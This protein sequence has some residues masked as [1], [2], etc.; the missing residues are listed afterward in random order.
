[1]TIMKEGGVVRAAA[2]AI[3]ITP[4]ASTL[5]FIPNCD[6][7]EIPQFCTKP[8]KYYTGFPHIPRIQAVSYHQPEPGLCCTNLFCLWN[9]PLYAILSCNI[10]CY[11]EWVG[12][13]GFSKVAATFNHVGGSLNLY[14]ATTGDVWVIPSFRIWAYVLHVEHI[15]YVIT[16]CGQHQRVIP[17]PLSIARYALLEESTTRKLISPSIDLFFKI[18]LFQVV[19]LIIV[20]LAIFSSYFLQVGMLLQSVAQFKSGT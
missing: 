1:M 19:F 5:E 2:V 8:S 7:L 4:Y 11:I 3:K 14:K 17:S 15:S 18:L 13:G 9:S 20:S 12:V 16:N 6:I 10:L